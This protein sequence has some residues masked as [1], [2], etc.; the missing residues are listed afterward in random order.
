MITEITVLR[1]QGL[2]VGPKDR[3]VLR[4]EGTAEYEGFARVEKLG[5]YRGS[6]PTVEFE[7]LA[8]LL[9][10]KG[11]FDMEPTY[12]AKGPSGRGFV[13]DAPGISLAVIRDG[14]MK[15]VVDYGRGG[16]VELREVQAGILDV[17]KTIPWQKVEADSK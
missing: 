4:K 6:I 12:R 9:V 11:F 5:R 3:M 7:R 2:G 14:K 1:T 13:T 16:P 8:K 15:S 10:D 17:F